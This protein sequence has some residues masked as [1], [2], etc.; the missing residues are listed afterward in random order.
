M[1]INPVMQSDS[2]TILACQVEVPNTLHKTQKFEHI[3]NMIGKFSAQLTTKPADLVL[4]QELSTIDYSRESFNA[5]AELAEP[6]ADVF[7]RCIVDVDTKRMDITHGR[8]LD[9]IST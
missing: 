9:L 5:L 2:C 7:K 8:S 1:N 3:R 6:I 4:L